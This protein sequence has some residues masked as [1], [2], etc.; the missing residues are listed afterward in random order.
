MGR[1][2]GQGAGVKETATRSQKCLFTPLIP[3]EI[4][5]TS[6]L[7]SRRRLKNRGV[8]RSCSQRH[9]LSSNSTR[10]SF[11]N[12]RCR[13]MHS[14]R[15]STACSANRH[16]LAATSKPPHRRCRICWWSISTT[17]TPSCGHSGGRRDTLPNCVV[18]TR[19]NGHAQAVWALSELITRT[20]FGSRINTF[21]DLYNCLLQ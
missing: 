5:E 6:G 8:F 1:F 3:G 21:S 4:R 14:S 17:Q 12:A 7:A 15:A 9:R 11:P 19:A 10:S 2:G 20:E 16:R 18:E 13:P